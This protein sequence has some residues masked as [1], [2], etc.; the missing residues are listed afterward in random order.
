MKRKEHQTKAHLCLGISEF[1]QM[2][3]FIGQSQNKISCLIMLI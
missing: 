1:C 3:N 2:D